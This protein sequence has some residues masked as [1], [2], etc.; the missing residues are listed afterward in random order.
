MF[1]DEYGAYSNPSLF[2]SITYRQIFYLNN[3]T[4]GANDWSRNSLSFQRV[5]SRFSGV[6][7]TQSFVFL[8]QCFMKYCLCFLSCLLS[9]GHCPFCLLRPLSFLSTSLHCFCL[10]HLVSSNFSS[11]VYKCILIFCYEYIMKN[12]IPIAYSM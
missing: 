7:V 12:K 6:C 5:H 9:F 11:V 4:T 2:S 3:E 10:T 8:V 1:T